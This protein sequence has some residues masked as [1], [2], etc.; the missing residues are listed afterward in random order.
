MNSTTASAPILYGIISYDRSA[1]VRWLMT[2]LKLPF[3]DKWL[4][5][6][7]KEI[8]SPEFLNINPFGR[9]PVL[10]SE[11]QTIFESSA[12]CAY[13]ADRYLDQGMAPAL[14]SNDRAEYQQWMYFASAT[15]DSFGSRIMII[16]DIPAGEVAT[17]KS[18]ALF[19]EFRDSIEVL[20]RALSKK[21][22]LVGNQF[23]AADICVSYHL[24]IC[25]LWPEYLAIVNAF[26]KV[27]AYLKRMQDIPSAKQAK[28]F[29]YEE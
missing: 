2:E 3:Q 21:S 22:Y 26:P 8:E 15:L 24:Y 28:V 25:S 29:S 9:V 17:E 6:E 23:S 18:K 11:E 7:T 27:G 13:L 16:E 5:R 12:I 1:K 14:S 10:R 4:D 20:E 19:D